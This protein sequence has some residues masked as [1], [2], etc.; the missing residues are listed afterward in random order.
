M[1]AVIGLRWSSPTACGHTEPPWRKSARP[2]VR[3]QV[4]GR[5]TAPRTVTCPFDDSSVY[6]SVHNHFSQERHL[7]SRRIYKERRSADL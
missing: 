2:I 5:T 7:V 4:A 6:T 1:N 3:K